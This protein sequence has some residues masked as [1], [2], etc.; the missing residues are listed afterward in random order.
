MKE[1]N[2][3]S[4]INTLNLIAV[5]SDKN[6]LTAKLCS[7]ACNFEAFCQQLTSSRLMILLGQGDED[8]SILFFGVLRGGSSPSESEQILKGIVELNFLVST[9][10]YR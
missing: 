4:F 9:P 5:L 1:K 3:F 6:I 7:F 2:L 8:R 10:S